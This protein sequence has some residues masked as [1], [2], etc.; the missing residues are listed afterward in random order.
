M[1]STSFSK[2]CALSN[3]WCIHTHS[4]PLLCLTHSVLLQ[5]VKS[6][7]PAKSTCEQ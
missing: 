6:Q 4:V 2:L 3:K 1:K 5:R 7:V